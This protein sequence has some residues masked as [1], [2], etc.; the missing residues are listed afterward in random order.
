MISIINSLNVLVF[1]L[2]NVSYGLLLA[3]IQNKYLF[4]TLLSLLIIHFIG[5]FYKHYTYKTIVCHIIITIMLILYSD[6]LILYYFNNVQP[7]WLSTFKFNILY[8][9]I[10]TNNILL[11]IYN[12]IYCKN[13]NNIDVL[14]HD[15]QHAFMYNEPHDIP[16]TNGIIYL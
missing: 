3:C 6:I 16:E 8:V 10:F 12:I 1:T 14:Y 15:Y 2:V 9:C 13:Y 7:Y 4:Y 5:Y 11:L